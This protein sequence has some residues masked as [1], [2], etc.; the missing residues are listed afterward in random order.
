MSATRITLGQYWPGASP[1]HAID[2]RTKLTLL[3]AYIVLAFVASTLP[4]LCL[5]F[6]PVA[7]AAVTARTPASVLLR[8]LAPLLFLLLFPIAYNLFFVAAGEPLLELG[9]VLVT[10]E[11]AYSA[12]FISLRMLLLFGVAVLLT[13]TT[14]PIALCDA[15]AGMLAP[16]ERFGVPGFELA[17]MASIALRFVPILMETFEHIRKAHSARGSSLG[18]GGPIARLR[19]LAPILTALFAQS[20]RQ[21]EELAQ[22]MESRCYNGSRRTHYHQLAFGRRDA[23]AVALVAFV[24]AA[25][26][27]WRVLAG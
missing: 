4:M 1:I 20:F 2:P 9:P 26:I 18:A 25:I 7:A 12:A 19:A 14:R 24:A 16:F 5:L 23:I 22:A 27:I 6:L 21:A 8:A 13:L 10:D 17:M 15:V 3:L 11:G